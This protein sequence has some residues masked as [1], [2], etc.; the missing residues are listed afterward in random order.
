M[1]LSNKTCANNNISHFTH[2]KYIH[3]NLCV[4]KSNEKKTEKKT[5]FPK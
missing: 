2:P 4:E 5:K 1:S 3:T